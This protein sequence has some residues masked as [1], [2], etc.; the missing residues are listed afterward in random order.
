MCCGRSP[1]RLFLLLLASVSE[2]RDRLDHNLRRRDE[3]VLVTHGLHGKAFSVQPR[4][5]TPT[6]GCVD[7]KVRVRPCPRGGLQN[8]ADAGGGRRSVRHVHLL[9]CG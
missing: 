8:G 4:I 9:K 1:L 6:V 3:S 2:A 5:A 7:V